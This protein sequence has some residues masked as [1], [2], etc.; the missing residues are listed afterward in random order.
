[1]GNC[2]GRNTNK[3]E[4]YSPQYQAP[5]RLRADNS[6]QDSKITAA[7]LRPLAS[8]RLGGFSED[9]SLHIQ[10]CIA[11]QEHLAQFTPGPL[12]GVFLL[13]IDHSLRGQE[14]LARRLFFRERYAARDQAERI[15]QFL[16]VVV[17]AIARQA[18]RE[19]LR[20][21]AG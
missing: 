3:A 4:R 6:N 16:R 19:T 2:I 12:L 18:G 10:E 21:E 20:A 1:G 13:G 9:P 15:S 17:A 11:R 8:H 14:L 7:G 5:S